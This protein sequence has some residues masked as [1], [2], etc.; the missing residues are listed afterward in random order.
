MQL[1]LP[2]STWTLAGSS[3]CRVGIHRTCLLEDQIEEAAEPGKLPGDE[4]LLQMTPL[5]REATMNILRCMFVLSSVALTNSPVFAQTSYCPLEEDY[6][7]GSVCDYVVGH[8]EAPDPCEE[9]NDIIQGPIDLELGCDGQGECIS[10]I[11]L[12][13]LEDVEGVDYYLDEGKRTA[14][15]EQQRVPTGGQIQRDYY[16]PANAPTNRQPLFR[17]HPVLD[18]SFSVGPVA[19]I[20]HTNGRNYFF[21]LYTVTIDDG[22]TVRVLPRG[23]EVFPYDKDLPPETT[24]GSWV[25]NTTDYCHV[26]EADGERYIVTT[27]LPVDR[28]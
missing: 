10:A 5:K 2:F 15:S 9:T 22:K 7:N 26:I 4:S 20:E 24:P 12:L 1:V 3:E 8:I 28:S 16:P 11:T 13:L 19:K 6:C 14:I 27:V 18:I 23:Q 17:F 21:Q 25:D